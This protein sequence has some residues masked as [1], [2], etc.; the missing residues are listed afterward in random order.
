[1]KINPV[2]KRETMVSARSFRLALI[3]LV[4]NGVLAVVALLNMYSVL[5]QVKVSAAIQYSSFLQI[6][7]F[8]GAIEFGMLMFIMPALT[9]GS[10]SGEREKQTLD[11]MLTTQMTPTQIVL[12]KLAAAFSTMFLLILSSFPALAIVFVYGG[13]T[14]T[15]VIMLMLCFIT[16]ALFTGSLGICFS[17]IFKKSTLATVVSYGVLAVVVGG[18]YGIN[19][20]VYSLSQMYLNNSVNLNASMS[21]VMVKQ[22]NSGG[23]IYLLLLNPAVTFYVTINKQAGDNQVINNIGRWFGAQP[24][25]F[26]MEHW[27]M[28]SIVVQLFF[29]FLFL[30]IAIKAVNPGLKSLKLKS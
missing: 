23:F 22:A 20:F 2:Y 9:S 25:N 30:A 27:V 26:V 7:M 6:Y 10:I 17:S 16:V 19:R 5:A 24:S 8:V 21:E 18:S 13:V 3:L 12:G 29:A 11:L 14:A 28:I 15:D 4:F 1:M